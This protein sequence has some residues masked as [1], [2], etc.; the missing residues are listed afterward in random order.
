[1]R[2]E[3]HSHGSGGIGTCPTAAQI[4][5]SA[6]TT[7]GSCD[8]HG[9]AVII[10]VELREPAGK[11]VKHIVVEAVHDIRPVKGNDLYL[12]LSVTNWG[13]TPAK[14]LLKLRVV[15]AHSG[16]N[17]SFFRTVLREIVGKVVG[18]FVLGFIWPLFRKDKR[19]FHDVI[20]NSAVKQVQRE[21]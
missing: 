17:L 9:T 16:Q 12:I 7:A 14:L 6:E 13:G 20:S 15:D 1:M 18:F 2:T 10:L 21:V 4:G 5:S 3:A 8:H 11:L 19:A